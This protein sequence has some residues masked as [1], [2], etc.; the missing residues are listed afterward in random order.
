MIFNHPNLICAFSS[1]LFKNMSFFYGDTKESLNN[2]KN[3]LAGLGINYR[4]LICAKQV[5]SGRV[6]YAKEEDKGSGALSYD[7]SIPDTDAFITDKKNLPLAVFTADCLSIFLYAPKASVIGLIHAGWRSTKENITTK[8]VQLMKK[9]FDIHAEDL[10]AGFGPAIREC[11]YEVS[12]EFKDNFVYGLKQKSGR[13]YLAL[14]GINKKELL[15]L[16]VC[17]ANIFDSGICTSCRN[18]EFFSYR[19]EGRGS[20]RMMSVMMLR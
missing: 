14:A 11:C 15:D 10:C 19:K 5:H 17:E 12:A 1:R 7:N 13:Y 3:F 18:S 4:D 2:R 20:G 16:G 9:E 8:A 6:R